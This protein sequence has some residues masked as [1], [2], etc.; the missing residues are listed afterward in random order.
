MTLRSWMKE[1]TT[2]NLLAGLTLAAVGIPE[3]MGYTK[4]IGTP[5]V[6]GLYTMILPALAFAL[7]GSSKRLVVGAD[8][9]T[10]AIVASALAGLILPSSTEY[11]GVT[12]LIA[13]L[14]GVMLL[15]ARVLKLGFLANFLSRT[16]LV[17]FLT[18]VGIQVMFSQLPSMLN[19]DRPNSSGLSG[20]WDVTTR[21]SQF[22]SSTLIVSLSTLIFLTM[23]YRLAP[24][25]PAALIALTAASVLSAHYKL[26]ELGIKTVGAIPGGLP[27][28]ALPT[29][30][31]LPISTTVGIAFS[32]F[33]VILAQSAATSSAYAFRHQDAFDENKDLIGLGFANFAAA[34]SGSFVV[35]GSPTR[36]SI[37]DEAGGRTQL[38]QVT[39]ALTA[40]AVLIFLTKP[41]SYLPDASLATI[42]F[43][44]G[45]KLV[46]G[47]G[48]A[49]ILKQSRMEFWLA[50]STCVTVVTLG[51]EQGILLSLL[52]SILYHVR[53]SYR[54]KTEVL[55]KDESGHWVARSQ[56]SEAR[57]IPGVL[58]YWFG[59]D[60]FYANI[61]HFVSQVH[62]L[63][64]NPPGQAPLR[65]LIVDAGAIT[66]ID[67]SASK[68]L[69]DLESELA[70]KQIRLAWAHVSLGLR[71]DMKRHKIL[72]DASVFETLRETLTNDSSPKY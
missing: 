23:M 63:I 11:V 66:G 50:V 32:C 60:L 30:S 35:N 40:L 72:D 19:I 6:T 59:A 67:Y 51:V 21:V 18:G 54:P 2:Q 47:H 39:A 68:R 38:A 26:V 36:T 28:L 14:A 10:A 17:G 31:A 57:D 25:W 15:L 24:K 42:V 7:L 41:L 34:F 65:L 46:D 9:A 64:K 1:G 43:L 27:H 22:H 45:A 4:I 58:V 53:R 52:L 69:S 55:V 29:L 61:N 56:S 12:S 48:L 13:L 33:I 44:I 62:D 20:L 16:V 37:V 5:V 71:A 70:L 3:V 8:S 49:D